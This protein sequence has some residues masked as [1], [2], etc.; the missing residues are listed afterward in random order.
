MLARASREQNSS[1]QP[2]QPDWVAQCGPA[3][4]LLEVDQQN[5][6]LKSANWP[7]QR[8]FTLVLMLLCVHPRANEHLKGSTKYRFKQEATRV[9]YCIVFNILLFFLLL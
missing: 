1:L 4:S 5:L 6:F 7:Q 8:P 9:L 2:L 3:S